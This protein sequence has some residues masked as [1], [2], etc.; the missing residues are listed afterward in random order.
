MHVVDQ[1]GAFGAQRAAADR[2]IGVAFDMEDPRLG[3][4]GAV[5]EAVHEN[6]ATDR[7]IGAVVAG[8]L[9]A[10]QLVLAR[11]GRLGHA[12]GK[13]QAR[14][15]GGGDAGGTQLEELS[16]AKSH[17]YLLILIGCTKLRA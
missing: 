14:A 15:G 9:G 2:V 8:F 11:L 6:P 10:Q 3:V 13:A 7:A 17:G 5:A 12:R 4:L 16:S 1:A